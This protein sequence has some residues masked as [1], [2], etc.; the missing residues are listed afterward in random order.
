MFHCRSSSASSSGRYFHV[1]GVGIRERSIGP[2]AP[3]G[4][5]VRPRALLPGEFILMANHPL[6]SLDPEQT[7][8]S[9]SMPDPSMQNA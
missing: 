9:Y 2:T 7:L 6:P 8:W 5:V 1:S 4:S 3:F